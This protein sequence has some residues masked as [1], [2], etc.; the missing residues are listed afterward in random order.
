M[1]Q[2]ATSGASRQSKPKRRRRN[3]RKKKNPSPVTWILIAGGV[4][5]A[6]GAGLGIYAYRKRKQSGVLPPGPTPGNGGGGGKTPSGG[7]G[8]GAKQNAPSFPYTTS[9]ARSVEQTWAIAFIAEEC[10][11]SVGELPRSV[12]KISDDIFYEMYGIR[13]IPGSGSRGT[14]WQPYIDSWI[15]IR[16]FVRSAAAE[17]GCAT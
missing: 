14:G 11:A 5:V 1:Y 10:D 13:K 17:A 3:T 8:G 2:G 4:A 9:E 16:D 7:G 15:R 6:T 12:D